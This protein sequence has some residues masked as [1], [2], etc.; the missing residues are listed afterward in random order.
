Q[1]ARG[2]PSSVPL[3]HAEIRIRGE[4]RGGS[5]HVG[6]RGLVRGFGAAGAP[7]DWASGG[8]RQR[9]HRTGASISGIMQVLVRFVDPRTHGLGREEIPLERL[10]LTKS[11]QVY[12]EESA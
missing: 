4:V 9:A 11:G 7:A 8:L 6:A 2:F 12:L 1:R 5:V 10:A 3:D